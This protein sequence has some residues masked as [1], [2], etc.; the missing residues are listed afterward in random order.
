MGKNRPLTIN[1]VARRGGLSTLKK[2]G[3]KKMREWGKRGGRPR[4][5]T[6]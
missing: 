1:E 6:R 2:Y 3:R 4:K 5:K